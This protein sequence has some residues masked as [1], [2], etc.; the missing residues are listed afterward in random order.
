MATA[1]DDDIKLLGV[2]HK[3]PLRVPLAQSRRGCL[4]PCLAAGDFTSLTL[5]GYGVGISET[6]LRD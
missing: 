2:Q 3:Q 5:R 6:K 1:N 4:P